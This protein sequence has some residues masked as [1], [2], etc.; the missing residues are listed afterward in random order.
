VLALVVSAAP[1][2]ADLCDLA[3]GRAQRLTAAEAGDASVHASMGTM[4]ASESMS[5][6]TTP[7]TATEHCAKHAAGGR[8]VASAHGCQ[9]HT[10]LLHVAATDYGV[11]RADSAE[12][13]AAL[14]ARLSAT[15]HATPMIALFLPASPPPRLASH[16]DRLSAQSS[17]PHSLPLGFAL[18]LRI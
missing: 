1:R 13:G 15:A 8:V 17:R 4:S 9:A 2:A 18:A 11:A 10:H 5:P 14:Q 3:C 16:A 12:T 7:N 6:A